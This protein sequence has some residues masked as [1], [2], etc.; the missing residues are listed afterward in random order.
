MD[1]AW[2]LIL[3]PKPESYDSRIESYSDTGVQSFRRRTACRQ[4][5]IVYH[6]SNHTVKAGLADLSLRKV[7]HRK[8]SCAD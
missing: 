5:Y 2:L 4:Y 7:K 8:R 3:Q 6:L 1:S